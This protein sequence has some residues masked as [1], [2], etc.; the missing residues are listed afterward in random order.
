MNERIVATELRGRV[1]FVLGCLSLLSTALVARAFDL[2][3]LRKEF[4]QDQGDARFLREV[5]IPTT[6]GMIV[7]RNGE[8]L[9]VSTPVESVWAH[10]RTLLGQRGALPALAPLIGLDTETLEN[11]LTQRADK[12]FVYL[13][14]Q[15]NPA[16]AEQIRALKIPGVNFQREYRRFYPAGEL[17]AHVV[18]FTNVDDNGQEGL[19]WIYNDWLKGTAGKKRVI[20]DR[21]GQTVEDVELISAAE[22]GQDLKL[23]ID[24][25]VQYIAYRELKATISE[26]R[27]A[28]G[29]VVVLDVSNGEVLAMVNQPSY[30]PNQRGQSDLSALRNRAVTDVFEP[31]SIIKP[32]TVAA[33]L[34]SGQFKPESQ[35]DTAPGTLRVGSHLVPDVRNFGVLDLTGILKKSSN[36]GASRLALALKSDHLWDAFHRFGF[37]QVT[38]SGFPGE[39]PGSLP[40]FRGWDDLEK[41]TL[42]YGYGLSVT[43]LQMAQ[44]YAALANHGRIRK[45][46][47]VRGA[48]Q[49][50]SAVIDPA[51]AAEVVKMMEAVT[52][53][54]G[55]GVRARVLHYRIAGKTGTARKASS[56]GYE[57]RYVAGFA[58]M[59]PASTPR[60][61][62]VVMINDPKGEA[63]YGG[64]ISAPLFSRVMA[65]TLRLMDV[66]PDQI[67]RTDLAPVETV[68]MDFREAADQ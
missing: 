6:R 29:S 59:A 13:R 53:P 27:A 40:D 18:G 9:A 7:D 49:P 5:E 58:G 44:S 17:L 2:Q 4:Y 61:V 50:D 64:Q 60:F 34:E 56:A 14:R 16:D 28:S 8:P 32:F 37:G 31:A 36:V 45:P 24:R 33:A 20:R 23:S 25:R 30:N 19:E 57:K 48:D 12:D 38:G 39:S 46:S 51:I 41:A 42:S 21:K 43:P 11:R 10:P 65:G 62:V 47:F 52:M 1:W 3:V 67:E 63:Y 35:I 68:E 26:H 22:P 54:D 55:T 66:P 15:M